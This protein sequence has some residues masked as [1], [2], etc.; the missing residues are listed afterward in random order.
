MSVINIKNIGLCER[1]GLAVIKLLRMIFVL[2]NQNTVPNIPLEDFVVHVLSTKLE[3]FI[4]VRPNMINYRNTK[5]LSII[6][7]IFL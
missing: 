6:C 5:Y 3:S 4:P 2:E 1:P 7:L